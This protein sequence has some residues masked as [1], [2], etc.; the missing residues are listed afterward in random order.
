MTDNTVITLS[1]IRTTH[2]NSTDFAG[3]ANIP[4]KLD[5]NGTEI[6]FR[7]EMLSLTDMWKAAGS[8]SGRAPNDWRALNSTIEFSDHVA[9][10]LNAGNSGNELFAVKRGGKSPGTWAHWQIALAYAKYLSPEFHMWC[11][12]VVRERME[13]NR[14]YPPT[15]PADLVE[16]MHRTFGICRMLAHKVTE[17]QGVVGSLTALVK[18][19]QKDDG[20]IL[21]RAHT[22]A[23]RAPKPHLN[24][25]P[26]RYIVTVGKDG[27]LRD[28]ERI[29][30]QM[31][32]VDQGRWDN[33]WQAITEFRPLL[34]AAK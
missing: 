24:L 34:L 15:I 26:G 31:L 11:N 14:S 20:E 32:L 10:M 25:D 8:P 9:A 19:M 7:K 2:I 28:S 18:P 17:I 27:E 33:I 6:H 22:R 5:Y 12:T 16:E 30:P 29:A 4:V 1:D 13:G 23:Q 21:V 3:S